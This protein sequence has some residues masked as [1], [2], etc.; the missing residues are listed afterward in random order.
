MPSTGMSR[1]TL[2]VW[3]HSPVALFGAKCG[4]VRLTAEAC[5]VGMRGGAELL[6]AERRRLVRWIPLFVAIELSLN[7]LGRGAGK[8]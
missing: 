8:G 5:T 6:R 3:W 4:L 1:S 7:P 2:R